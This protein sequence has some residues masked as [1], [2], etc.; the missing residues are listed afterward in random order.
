MG[1]MLFLAAANND[2]KAPALLIARF[3]PQVTIITAAVLG[4]NSTKK[5]MLQHALPLLL[6][7]A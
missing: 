5:W 3:I 7:T 4:G 2:V 1:M 6:P